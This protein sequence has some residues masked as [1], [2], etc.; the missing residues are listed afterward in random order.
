M[1]DFDW[2]IKIGRF[3]MSFIV[4][5]NFCGLSLMIGKEFGVVGYDEVY[6]FTMQLGYLQFTI[7]LT[8]SED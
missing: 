2:G 7:G 5:D 1:N 8:K 6:H 4:N 3:F